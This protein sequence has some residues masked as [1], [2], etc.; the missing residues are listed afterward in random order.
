MSKLILII[1]SILFFSC[2]RKEKEYKEL[3]QFE[4]KVEIVENNQS[5][6]LIIIVKLFALK[7]DVYQVYFTEDYLLTFYENESIRISKKGSDS[8]EDLV[9]SIPVENYIDRFRLDLGSINQEFIKIKEITLIYNSSKINIDS[10]EIKEYFIY[11]EFI[12]EIDSTGIIEFKRNE[13]LNE[14]VKFDPYLTM[15]PVLVRFLKKIQT[16]E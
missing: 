8:F 10:S 2:S 3:R 9:F 5:N 12:S 11:N 14:K 7:P 1:L 15:K 6:N 13:S 4:K 16:V